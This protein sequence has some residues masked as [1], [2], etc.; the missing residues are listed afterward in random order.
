MTEHLD[1][2]SRALSPQ[3]LG[4]CVSET[5]PT[6]SLNSGVPPLVP[7][8]GTS[9]TSAPFRV[10]HSTL[11]LPLQ[12]G[13]RFFLPPVPP[14]LSES[15]CNVPGSRN[16]FLEQPMRVATFRLMEMRGRR[17]LPLLGWVFALL[18]QGVVSLASY[19]H[20]LL[21]HASS[22]FGMSNV[23]EFI[24]SLR[25]LS[26]GLFPSPGS[27]CGFQ[28][29]DTFRVASD[30]DVTID[31]RTRWGHLSRERWV[32]LR[33]STQAASCR[34]TTPFNRDHAATAIAGCCTGLG[35]R[36]RRLGA[37]QAGKGTW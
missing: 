34:T 22:R 25:S 30:P 1:P 29:L 28:A 10:G 27:R 18:T 13:L 23:T 16:P 31:A 24:G 36:P 3:A 19:P 7:P 33:R 17:D 15:S 37:T 32:C 2:R 8:F 35:G 21:A 20:A 14:G 26:H 9:R 5:G 12:R 6:L 4:T 11:S